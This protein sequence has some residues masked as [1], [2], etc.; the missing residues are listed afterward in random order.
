[1]L[2]PNEHLIGAGKMYPDAWKQVDVFRQDKGRD[3]PDWP[4]W[5][6]MPMAAWYAIVS[7]GGANR[8]GLDMIGD[9]AKLAA[10]GT[11]RYSQGIYQFD[12]D[13][14]NAIIDTVPSGD[15]PSEVLYRLPE[16]SLYIETPC[17]KWFDTD[18]HG[19]WVHLEWDA[20]TNRHELRLLLNT[21]GTLAPV[22]I[23]IGKW[24]LTEAIDRAI[25]EA[26]A[27]S[28]IAGIDANLPAN[29]PELMAK[30]LYGIVSLVLYVCSEEPEIDDERQP[31]T[32]PRRPTPKRTKQGWRLFP[33]EKPR[34]WRVGHETGKNL[35]QPDIYE[36]DGR[37]VRPHL[38]RAHWHGYWTGPREGDRKFKYKWLP[39]M[40][41]VSKNS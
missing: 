9:V 20:N 6:F 4:A 19:F 11:W 1:M 7:G 25:S 16:W 18:M 21:D 36:S 17:G 2:L 32:G 10:I 29:L 28:R 5:C 35:R 12:P 13:F 39:P 15:L 27:Q 40:L 37:T 34:I 30:Q 22:P 8:L 23:H 33:A 41:I 26:K 24:T 38:R 14:Y 31:G 3:L